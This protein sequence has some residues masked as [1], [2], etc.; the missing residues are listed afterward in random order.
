MA[1]LG[2]IFDPFGGCCEPSGPFTTRRYN[3]DGTRVWIY[4]QDND[5]VDPTLVDAAGPLVYSSFDGYIYSG[6]LNGG[7]YPHALQTTSR[8]MIY[9]FDVLGTVIRTIPWPSAGPFYNPQELIHVD[10]LGN[11]YTFKQSSG[12]GNDAGLAKWSNA[13]VSQWGISEINMPFVNPITGKLETYLLDSMAVPPGGGNVYIL[14]Y[15]ASGGGVPNRVIGVFNE[16][17]GALVTSYPIWEWA[18]F[19]AGGYT[20]AYPINAKLKFGEGK[21]W[22]YG[23]GYHPRHSSGTPA[24]FYEGG[25][26]RYTTGGV[27]ETFISNGPNDNGG[28]NMSRVTGI[29]FAMGDLFFSSHYSILDGANMARCSLA[30]AYSWR[31]KLSDTPCDARGMAVLSSGVSI[32]NSFWYTPSSQDFV[33]ESLNADGTVNWTKAS[34]HFPVTI[35]NTFHYATDGSRFFIGS[36]TTE[37]N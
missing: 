2:W 6:N 11:I 19:D 20:R 34:E 37:K 22:V 30:G 12:A 29:G 35:R 36:Q 9:V 13:M 33:L 3:S 21:L 26:F 25:V 15:G 4:E 27:Y 32:T 10:D 24:E 8:V 31:K 14:G 1:C 17:T 18:A 28:Y 23:E 5:S 16:T 7:A